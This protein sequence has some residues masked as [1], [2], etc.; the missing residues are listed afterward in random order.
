MRTADSIDPATRTLL[1]EVDVDNSNGELLPGAYTEVH[2]KVPNGVPSLILPVT[3]L[4][5][6]SQ[7][8]QVAT[9]QGGNRAAAYKHSAWPRYGNGSGSGLRLDG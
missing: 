3:A 5:F 9:V 2:L 8:L 7:G 4:I 1:V 6:R